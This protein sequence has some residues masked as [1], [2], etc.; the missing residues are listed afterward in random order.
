MFNAY[1]SDVEVSMSVGSQ[2]VLTQKAVTFLN[3]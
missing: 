1:A 2:A 3:P